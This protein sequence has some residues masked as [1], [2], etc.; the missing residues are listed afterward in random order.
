MAGPWEKYQAQAVPDS[1]KPWEKFTAIKE[2]SRTLPANAGLANFAASVAGLPADTIQNAINLIRATQGTVAG[3]FGLTDWMPPRLKGSP[4]TS[5]WIKEKLRGT[6][7]AGLS[8][9]SPAKSSLEQAQFDLVS[10]GGFIP[11]G[12]IPA[13][14]SMAAERFLGP[15]WAGVGALAPQAAITAYNAARAPSLARQESQNTVRDETFRQGREAGYV[16]PPSAAGAGVTSNI[17]ESFGGKAATGQKAVSV[18]QKVTD[19]LARKE[20]GLPPNAA[21]SVDA[22]EARRKVLAE[23][24][25]EVAKLSKD[26][27]GT[28][29]KL[30]ETRNEATQYFREYDSTQRVA[31][32]KKANRLKADAAGMET[33]LESIALQHGMP[34]LIPEL[35]A[36]R[37]AIAKT[38]DVERALNV[39]T[40]SVSAPVLGR[41]VDKGK[42]V[43]GGLEVAGRFQQAFPHF[44]REGE[45]VTSPEVSATNIMAAGALGY[46]G[47]QALGLPGVAAAGI[48]FLRGGARAGLLSSPVQNALLPNY[49]P[50]VTPAPSPLLLYQ[51]GLLEQPPSKQK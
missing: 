39:G 15:E 23:P 32:L 50:A 38:H 7:M 21:I 1:P 46:G 10:R 37:V 24:Y 18:N 6:G 42:P 5:E 49:G 3:Q 35:R 14:G 4:G 47:Y 29:E 20:A 30:K 9:D 16:V 41:M 27:A 22:L 13:A 45:K 11:G 44:M 8:P 17:L 51:L 28:L 25:R 26:A 33:Q 43:S 12:A 40:G 48:P 36:A 31:A 19:A 34:D 2:E